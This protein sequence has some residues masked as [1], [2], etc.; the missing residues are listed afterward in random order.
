LVAAGISVFV[1]LLTDEQAEP[2]PEVAELWE[3]VWWQITD[4]TAGGF[5][6]NATKIYELT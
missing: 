3:P 4:V 5:Y 2:D 1:I 6:A